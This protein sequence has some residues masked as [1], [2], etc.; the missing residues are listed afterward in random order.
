MKNKISA[1]IVFNLLWLASSVFGAEVSL[2]P[3]NSV[4]FDCVNS[5]TFTKKESKKI[6]GQP[7][8][9]TVNLS[10]DTAGT[11]LTINLQNNSQAVSESALYAFDLGLPIKF[12]SVNRLA[13]MFSL[14]P[15][16]SNWFGPTDLAKPTNGMGASTFAVRDMIFGNPEDFL[17]K[18]KTLS[19]GFLRSGQSGK[20]VVKLAGGVEAKTRTLKIDPVAYFLSNDLAN[21]NKRIQ[22]ASTGVQK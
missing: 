16:G 17:D 22:I 6:D 2:K 8:S 19:A 15:A 14:F 9:A 11:L 13:A 1:L 12:L 3:G 20:I 7:V 10:L 18:Q 4:A 5:Y 21:P